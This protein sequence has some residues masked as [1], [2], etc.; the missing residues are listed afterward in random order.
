MA[1]VLGQARQ[2]A[3]WSLGCTDPV[4]GPRVG[5]VPSTQNLPKKLGGHPGQTRGTSRGARM[6]SQPDAR[7]PLGSGMMR[8][9]S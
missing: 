8:G 5:P 2:E 7:S 9:G 1:C 3:T 4:G 6:L